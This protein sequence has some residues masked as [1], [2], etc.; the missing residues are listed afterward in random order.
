MT[1]KNEFEHDGAYEANEHAGDGPG[2]VELLPVDRQQDDRH[3]RA[4]GDRE[5]QSDEEGHVEA[6]QRYGQDYGRHRD[7]DGRVT[8][9]LELLA[10]GRLAAADDVGV[11]RPTCSPGSSRRA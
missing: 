3:V 1:P 5:G 7:A 4:G 6:L 8:G 2:G 10:L 11:T 9:G